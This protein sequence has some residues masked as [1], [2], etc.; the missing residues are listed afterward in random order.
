MNGL[1]ESYVLIPFDLSFDAFVS[2]QIGE[3]Y[4]GFSKF[5]KVETIRMCSKICFNRLY[6]FFSI[7][8]FV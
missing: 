4:K 1:M 6:F 3:L 7:V 8:D 5:G 2:D